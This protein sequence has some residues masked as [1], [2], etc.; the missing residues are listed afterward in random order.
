MKKRKLG[1]SLEVSEIGLGCMGM[2]YGY[3]APKD[4]QDMIKL[5]RKAVELRI[6]F[7]DTA[8][9]YGPYANEELIGEALE[10]FK[11]EVIIA[12]KFGFDIKDGK[13]VGLNSKP[14]HI[15][16]AVEGSLK[17]LRIDRIDLLY[18]HRVDPEVPIE[19]VAYTVQKLMEE[20]KV[21]YWGLSEASPKTIRRAHNVLPLSAIQNEFSLWW[22]EEEVLKLLEELNIGLVAFSPLGRGFFSGKITPD[23]NFEE[24]DMRP[25]F[26][27][28]HKENLEQNLKII[29]FLKEI[30]IS[31]NA[32]PSQIALAWVLH[33]KP[34]IVPIPGTT[35][36]E[37]LVENIKATEISFTAEEVKHIN[38]MLS[39]IEIKGER[40]PKELQ[41]FVEK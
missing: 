9:M 37:H 18:Q 12:T 13:R 14:E 27:R 3:G 1:Q 21:K 23:T 29:E 24:S 20:D 5:I 2:S 36:L 10:P 6:N 4:K 17:R 16:E 26:P 7:F 15:K 11:K 30:A 31:K 8:E 40:Y 41:K 33:Q 25:K 38:D 39:S 22:H 32:T 35:K 34:W 19:D 28:F